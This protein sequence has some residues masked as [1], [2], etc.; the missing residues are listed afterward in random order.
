MH[1]LSFQ[2]HWFQRMFYFIT[3]LTFLS[4][5]WCNGL[6]KSISFTYQEIILGV[7]IHFKWRKLFEKVA[8]KSLKRG[9]QA[10]HPYFCANALIGAIL[11]LF[12]H[13]NLNILHSGKKITQWTHLATLSTNL[14]ETVEIQY[15]CTLIIL[16]LKNKK[17]ALNSKKI[18]K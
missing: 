16:K 7:K 14:S 4:E 3:H 11:W 10:E 15:A 12:S 1:S 5:C 18:G 9:H 13:Q 2:T 8:K 6:I 17:T